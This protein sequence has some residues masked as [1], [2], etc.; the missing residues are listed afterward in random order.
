M[1]SLLRDNKPN[2][3]AAV[4]LPL[5][6]LPSEFWVT[7][8]LPEAQRTLAAFHRQLLPVRFY[9]LHHPLNRGGAELIDL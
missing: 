7:S 2:E 4:W 3:D 6:A 5:D 9:F 1:F 8:Q